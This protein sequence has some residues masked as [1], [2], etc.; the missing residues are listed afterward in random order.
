MSEVPPKDNADQLSAEDL[1]A[2]L[3]VA[4]QLQKAL[5]HGDT[6]VAEQLAKRR[7][8]LLQLLEY[9]VANIDNPNIDRSLLPM[10]Q[11]MLGID[12]RDV[13]KELAERDEEDQ[14]KTKEEIERINKVMIY[15]IYKIVNPHQLAGETS[16]ENFI[17][18]VK[19]RGIKEAMKYEG[20]EHAKDFH[21]DDLKNLEGYRH[22]ALDAIH[23]AGSRGGGLGR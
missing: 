16:M 8:E 19:T 7:E 12:V 10:L 22:S 9:M 17:S 2:L 11:Q 3:N 14:E 6:E 21:K 23:K 13:A 15:E 1:L 18:N 4:Y 5:A 20:A